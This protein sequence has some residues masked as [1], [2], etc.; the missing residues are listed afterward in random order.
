MKTKDDKEDDM[1]PDTADGL[2]CKL[3]HLGEDEVELYRRHDQGE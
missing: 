2:W 3:L 1:H